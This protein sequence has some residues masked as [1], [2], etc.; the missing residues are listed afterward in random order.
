MTHPI[1]TEEISFY[2]QDG[3]R[4]KINRLS[5]IRNDV[6]KH[7]WTTIED[8]KALGSLFNEEGWELELRT[9]REDN[10]VYYAFNKKPGL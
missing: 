7:I 2:F 4:E 9:K 10:Y 3:N 5:E 6:I 8:E 1:N